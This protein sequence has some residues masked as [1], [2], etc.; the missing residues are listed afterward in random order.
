METSRELEK[1]GEE[2][3][4]PFSP[5]LINEDEFQ[6]AMGR[7][8]RYLQILKEWKQKAHSKLRTSARDLEKDLGEGRV[9]P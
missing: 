8:E 7:L 6:A 2:K 3:A 5:R 1:S 4:S 9:K